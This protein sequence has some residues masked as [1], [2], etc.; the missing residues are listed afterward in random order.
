MRLSNLVIV[1]GIVTGVTVGGTA[2]ADDNPRGLYLSLGDSIAFG[3]DPLVEDMT[4][5]DNYVGYPEYMAQQGNNLV[6]NAGCPGETSSSFL[7]RVEDATRRTARSTS[8]SMASK[9]STFPVPSQQGHSSV[10]W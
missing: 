1:V 2:L 6:D 8:D 10:Y 4:D 7:S 5:P 3:M 9:E